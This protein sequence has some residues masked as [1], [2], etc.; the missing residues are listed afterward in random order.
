MSWKKRFHALV[1]VIDDEDIKGIT[2]DEVVRFASTNG[3]YYANALQKVKSGGSAPWNWAAF[4]VPPFWFAYRRLWKHALISAVLVFIPF[5]NIAACFYWGTK[6]T[7]IYLG[8]CAEKIK[9]IRL[10]S[11][12]G[13]DVNQAL[14]SGGGT[15]RIWVI[16]LGCIL[17]PPLAVMVP[18]PCGEENDAMT[19]NLSVAY[20]A[21]SYLKMLDKIST[22][23]N[24]YITGEQ[25]TIAEKEMDK[26][27]RLLVGRC[28]NKTAALELAQARRSLGSVGGHSESVTN[29]QEAQM[30]FDSFI[31]MRKDL[32]KYSAH[33]RD[34]L[35]SLWR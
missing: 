19:R 10:K 17:V 4:L 29:A 3:A 6:G 31:S 11:I 25:L 23:G 34:P 16:A 27:E 7:R 32:K 26:I 24:R 8:D 15:S 2:E 18:E 35:N 1:P 22:Q 28:A 14:S 21:Y 30:A 9:Q 33:Y 20:R 13:H 5:L 12:A